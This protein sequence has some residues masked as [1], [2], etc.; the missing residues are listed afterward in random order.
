LNVDDSSWRFGLFAPSGLIGAAAQ[1]VVATV[2]LLAWIAELL[3]GGRFGLFAPSGLI[4]AAAQPATFTRRAALVDLAQLSDA[5]G[6]GGRRRSRK[7]WL[8]RVAEAGRPPSRGSFEWPRG[9]QVSALPGAPLPALARRVT[10]LRE[11]H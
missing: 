10:Q 6:E 7:P 3:D 8:L 4:G 9:R 2:S 11:D 1:P 5:P